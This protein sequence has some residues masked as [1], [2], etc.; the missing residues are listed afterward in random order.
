MAS[1][2]KKWEKKQ[3]QQ[4]CTE[5]QLFPEF[6][7]VGRLWTLV[8]ISVRYLT[9]MDD[10]YRSQGFIWFNICFGFYVYINN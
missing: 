8:L 5:F 4:K 3:Q 1:S 9:A 10:L 7:W 2:Q 6:A